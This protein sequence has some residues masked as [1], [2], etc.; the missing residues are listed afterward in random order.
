MSTEGS[1][2][3]KRSNTRFYVLAVLAIL[4]AAGTAVYYCF[5]RSTPEMVESSLD[6]HSGVTFTIRNANWIACTLR[7]FRGEIRAFGEE[8]VTF[9]SQDI[10]LAADSRTT[11]TMPVKVSSA[12]QAVAKH[13]TTHS[14]FPVSVS[15]GPSRIDPWNLA[16]LNKPLWAYH[17]RDMPC[18]TASKHT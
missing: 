10:V 18:P 9:G 13:C 8:I 6:M 14:T 7:N 5:P 3:A 16:S 17:D 11:F 4:G 1:T 15:A 12:S 2:T